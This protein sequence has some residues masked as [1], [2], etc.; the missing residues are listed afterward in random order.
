MLLYLDRSLKKK[1]KTIYLMSPFC[2]VRIAEV[3][4]SFF[5]VLVNV[6]LTVVSEL[7]PSWIIMFA[8]LVNI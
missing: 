3:F 5:N 8:A 4:F 6:N 1:K 2:F 7:T